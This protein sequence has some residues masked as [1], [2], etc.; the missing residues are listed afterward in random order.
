M[1]GLDT[2]CSFYL[3]LNRFESLFTLLLSFSSTEDAS[4]MS[5]YDSG[6]QWY[7]SQPFPFTQPKPLLP[8]QTAAERTL[9]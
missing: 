6:V 2:R 7:N 4:P 3:T 5:L 9:K 1:T 8:G